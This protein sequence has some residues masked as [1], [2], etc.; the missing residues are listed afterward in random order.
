MERK[1]PKKPERV[2][3]VPSNQFVR[4]R[5]FSPVPKGL[6][7]AKLIREEDPETGK[8]LPPRYR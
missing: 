3:R 5:G 7:P 2:H 4:I 1:R 8:S 6:M